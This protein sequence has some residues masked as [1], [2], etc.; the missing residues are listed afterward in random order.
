MPR[1]A[2]EQIAA[3]LPPSRGARRAKPQAAVP[4][5][6]ITVTTTVRWRGRTSHSRWKICCQVPSTGWPSAD[7]H[8][9]RG[10]HQRG[11][12]VRV[13]VAVVPGLLVAVVAAG[14]DQPVEHARARR[15]PGPARTRPTPTRRVLPD[16]EDA[17]TTPVGTPDVVD[18]LGHLPGDV[19]HVA[20]A[21]GFAARVVL[22]GPW[23]APRE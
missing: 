19:V 10:A 22:G 12:Q 2:R 21:G 9:Q 17:A 6:P 8:G 20:V 13:A 14:R 11:L 23:L 3:Q 1:I 15:A 5:S 16:G 18:H 7:G 4:H